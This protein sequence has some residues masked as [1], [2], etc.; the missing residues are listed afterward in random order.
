MKRWEWPKGTSPEHLVV[1]ND[2]LVVVDEY[3]SHMH[4]FDPE[5]GTWLRLPDP[6]LNDCSGRGV[7]VLAGKIYVI[8]GSVHIAGSPLRGEMVADV[9]IFDGHE[10]SAGPPLPSP[11]SSDLTGASAS[12]D[13]I[14]FVP[15]VNHDIY[16][17]S[18]CAFVLRGEAWH[19]HV[20]AYDK[21]GPRCAITPYCA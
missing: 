17:D 15:T 6:P 20:V 12:A 2:K 18:R 21:I 10:W 16:E 9:Y 3:R 13:S 11:A 5:T 7:A 8:G 4:S 19:T 1:L 14:L